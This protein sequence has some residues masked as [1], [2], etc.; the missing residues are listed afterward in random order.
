MPAGVCDN[1]STCP[2][3]LPPSPHERGRGKW[4]Y[5]AA[6][7]TALESTMTGAAFFV[8]ACA[9][10]GAGRSPAQ[11]G[12]SPQQSF[13]RPRLRGRM[14]HAPVARTVANEANEQGSVTPK[15]AGDL[16]ELRG[17]AQRA[18]GSRGKGAHCLASLT[19]IFQLMPL[20]S[21]K[22]KSSP[23]DAM[24]Q[25]FVKSQTWAGGV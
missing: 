8:S 4:V 6:P 25:H 3:P 20:P 9:F 12:R 5:R 11:S 15:A 21:G 16:C 18:R 1:Q 19:H 14:S 2:F 17:A 24:P 13:P 23:F 22:G 10:W 7:C